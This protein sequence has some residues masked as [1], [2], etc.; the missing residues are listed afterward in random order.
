MKEKRFVMKK[1]LLL[2][3][4]FILV[5]VFGPLKANAAA[6]EIFG[7]KEEAMVNTSM[8][9]AEF[10]IENAGS[11]TR[12]YIGINVTEG[13]VKEVN[14][15]LT[16][17]SEHFTY[18]STRAASGWT[19]KETKNDDG[20]VTFTFTNSTGVATGKHLLATVSLNVDSTATAT[21]TCT[22]TLSG[23]P[24][25]PTTP[26]CKVVDG[27]YYNNTG[28][29]VT[30]E[31]Y[32]KACNTSNPETGAFLPVAVIGVGI[33]LV[34]GLFFATKNNKMYQV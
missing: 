2:G 11:N 34:I 23:A 31:E 5:M 33:M 3:V 32:E 26:K 21:D 18:R 15:T 9:G 4:L 10:A 25:T 8:G 16:I 19:K 6:Y 14:T 24:S 27:K 22:I 29:E 12:L 1:G 13:T 7:A 17:N 28:V 30:K 20:T